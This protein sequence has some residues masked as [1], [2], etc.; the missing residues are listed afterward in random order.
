M[1]TDKTIKRLKGISQCSENGHKVK[2]VF[3]LMTNYPDL[4]QEVSESIGRNR[5]AKTPGVDGETHQQITGRL[6]S[7]REDLATG[8]YRPQPTRRVYIPKKNGKFRPLGIPTASDKLV[9]AI[10]ARILEEIYEPVFSDHSHGFR[11]GRSC[12]TALDEFK[13]NWKGTKWIIEADIRGCFDNIDHDVLLGLLAKRIEDRRFLKLIKAFLK[14]GYLEDWNYQH[15]YSGTPQGGTVSPILANIYLHELDEWLQTKAVAYNKG[16]G[17]AQTSEYKRLYRRYQRTLYRARDLRKAGRNQE[18]EELEPEIKRRKEQY[19]ACPTS[20]SQDPNFRRMRF[21]RYADDFVISIIGPK[22]EARSILAELNAFMAGT[23]KV[24][25]AKEK[26]G[27]VHGSKGTRFLGYDLKI[28]VNANR[29]VKVLGG[30]RRSMM[31]GIATLEWPMELA[32]K[33]AW[34]RGYIDNIQD[35]KTRPRTPLLNLGEEEIIRRYAQELRGISNYYSRAKNWRHVGNLLHWWCKDSLARTLGKK[36]RAKK[37][38]T[39]ARYNM[40]DAFGVQV[41]G[42]VTALLPPKR[43]KRSTSFYTDFKPKGSIPCFQR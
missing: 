18:A 42:K 39:Y 40:N 35:K 16:T 36:N 7:I 11:K 3:Q 19:L 27:I 17:R 26:T 8:Q 24:E 23:L 38:R 9:Q 10:V 14:A 34:E 13:H 25:L 6:N 43:W 21:I 4:W 41:D 37:T 22:A 29:V 32:T 12:H 28:V 5:G 2:R 20:E 31:S 33:F 30:T 1:L 15:T